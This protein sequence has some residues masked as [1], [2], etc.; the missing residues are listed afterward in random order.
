[1]TAPAAAVVTIDTLG[2]AFDTLL[3]VYTGGSVDTLVLVAGNDDAGPDTIQSRVRFETFAG[4]IYWIAVDGFGGSS[5]RAVLNWRQGGP[6]L[7]DLVVDEPGLLPQITLEPFTAADCDVQ[8]GCLPAGR[9]R[10]LR[11][12]AS[13]RN[14]G[15]ADLALGDPT[16]N[17]L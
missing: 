4:E 15:T 16:S 10:L 7:P 2:S 14:I 11:L 9:R 5:G 12:T 17:P 13:I 8:Q 3:G 1:W 6:A